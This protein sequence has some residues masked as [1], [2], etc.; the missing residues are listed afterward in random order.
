MLQA[1]G[2]HNIDLVI[3]IFLVVASLRGSDSPAACLFVRVGVFTADIQL[4][5]ECVGPCEHMFDGVNL[6]VLRVAALSQVAG[7]GGHVEGAA[8]GGGKLLPNHCSGG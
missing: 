6:R 4:R 5:A 8:A 2:V 3:I 1:N 7:G